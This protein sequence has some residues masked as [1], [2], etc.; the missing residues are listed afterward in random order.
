MDESYGLRVTSYELQSGMFNSQL[1]TCNLFSKEVI[2]LIQVILKDEWLPS[3]Q[4]FGKPDEVV[5]RALRGFLVDRLTERI[6]DYRRRVQRWE[7]KFGCSYREFR[8][9]S[10]SS[11]KFIRSL[12][13]MHPTWEADVM[14]W[15]FD[16]K[17]FEKCMETLKTVIGKF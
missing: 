17:G 4:E 13:T 3:I 15:E 6:D 14:E 7:Q 2:F 16:Q 11:E 12:D 1:A 9:K 5:D 10:R 8:R